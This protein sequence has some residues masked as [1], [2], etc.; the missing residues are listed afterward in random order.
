MKSFWQRL[1]VKSIKPRSKFA[2]SPISSDTVIC[3]SCASY[4]A[5]QALSFV[6]QDILEEAG[7]FYTYVRSP[8]NAGFTPTTSRELLHS[9][10]SDIGVIV[11][12]NDAVIGESNATNLAVVQV[13]CGDEE[14]GLAMAK[15][16][17]QNLISKASPLALVTN[18]L[19][20]IIPAL[21]C[22]AAVV[23]LDNVP[24]APFEPNYVAERE[25]GDPVS[26][27]FP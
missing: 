21:R 24:Y 4:G 26:P 1:G 11:L 19:K 9:V 3:I 8:G 7:F 6:L 5:S 18:R 23:I 16:L 25:S 2:T 13:L 17:T 15:A 20:T 14:Q 10:V 27:S 22:D 12:I